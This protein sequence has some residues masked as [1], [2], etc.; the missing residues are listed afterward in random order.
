MHVPTPS[1]LVYIYL[2]T[3]VFCD[4]NQSNTSHGVYNNSKRAPAWLVVELFSP[5]SHSM[6]EVHTTGTYNGIVE[7]ATLM[8]H[9]SLIYVHGRRHPL[10]IQEWYTLP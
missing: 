10:P 8:K 9:P 3:L 4:I 5:T 1:Y 6:N 7:V 2:T